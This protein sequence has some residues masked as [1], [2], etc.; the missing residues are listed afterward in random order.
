M[1][2]K[3][4]IKEELNYLIAR[5]ELL[6]HAEAYNKFPD[7]FKSFSKE[8]KEK[9]T[10]ENFISGYPAWYDR[11]LRIVSALCPLRKEEFQTLYYADRKGKATQYDTYTIRDYLQ[12]MVVRR[13]YEDIFD[14]TSACLTRVRLQQAIV[15]GIRDGLDRG[16]DD[17]V[18]VL[19]FDLFS[20]ELAAA[21]ELL[22]KGHIRAAGAVAGVILEGHLKYLHTKHKLARAGKNPTISKLNDALK[23]AGVYD[24]AVWRRIQF[25][26]DVRNSYSHK[27]SSDPPVGNVEKLISETK[28]LMAQVT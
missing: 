19:Q 4:K 22:A 17:I 3:E 25:L 13:G 21:Q 23:D 24:Q 20:D 12:G 18:G 1:T 6:Y 9:L 8:A 2:T 16:L 5:I 27:A 28:E 15:E 14:A 10:N 26:G 7:K 11:A